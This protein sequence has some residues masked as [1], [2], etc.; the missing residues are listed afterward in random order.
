MPVKEWGDGEYMT[1]MKKSESALDKDLHRPY[2]VNRIFRS[3]QQDNFKNFYQFLKSSVKRL[4][5]S[6]PFRDLPQEKI[7]AIVLG[8]ISALFFAYYLFFSG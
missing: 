4:N 2:V 5:L 6:N 8:F 1:L 3:I 7:I